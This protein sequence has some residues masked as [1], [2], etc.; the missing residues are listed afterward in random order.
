MRITGIKKV[1]GFF[2]FAVTT[3]PPPHAPPPP[4]PPSP[5]RLVFLFLIHL[6][7]RGPCTAL[8]RCQFVAISL[9]ITQIVSKLTR[10]RL[11]RGY[12]QIKT[13]FNYTHFDLLIYATSF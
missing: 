11:L 2:K 13:I 8:K 6:N 1:K 4:P 3:A 9:S 10:G 12:N 5:N 7:L